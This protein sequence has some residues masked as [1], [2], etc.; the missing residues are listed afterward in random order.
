MKFYVIMFVLSQYMSNF[1]QFTFIRCQSVVTLKTRL[2]LCSQFR[3]HDAMMRRGKSY[4]DEKEID[5]KGKGK[6]GGMR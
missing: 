3:F 2:S 1:D 4:D 6:V 5:G